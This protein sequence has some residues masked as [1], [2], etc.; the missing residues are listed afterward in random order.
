MSKKQKRSVSQRQIN[1]E[2]MLA[3]AA[4]PR[5]GGRRPL[6]S[7]EF[8]PDYSHVITDLKRIGVLAGSFIVILVALSFFLK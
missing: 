4:T 7:E 1:Q 2:P 3:A 5:S 6:L 8:N